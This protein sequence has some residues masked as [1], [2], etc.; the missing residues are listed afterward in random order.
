MKNEVLSLPEIE[1]ILDRTKYLLK[2]LGE[3]VN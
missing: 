1:N 2:K 3:K